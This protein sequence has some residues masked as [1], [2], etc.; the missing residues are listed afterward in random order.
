M[1]NFTLSSSF[2]SIGKLILHT[3]YTSM[4][5]SIDSCQNGVSGDQYHLTVSRAQVSAH[6]GRVFFEVFRWQV[7]SFQMIA[8][9]SLIFSIRINMLCLS[10]THIKILISNW[11]RTRKFSQLGYYRQGRQL[12][13]TLPT[14]AMRWSRSTSNFNGL[15]GQNMTGEF[16]RKIYAASWNLFFTV[17][18]EA[19]RVLGQLVM[20]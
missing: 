3:Y 14:T 16:M 12:L 11:P 10:A 15:I 5:G 19:D 9:S 20:F 2:G 6:R 4:L 1:F 17:T 13:L 18:A 7:T 8:G